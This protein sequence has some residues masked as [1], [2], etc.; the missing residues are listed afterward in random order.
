MVRPVIVCPLHVPAGHI[1]TGLPR[2][3]QHDRPVRS[4]GENL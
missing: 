1:I 2:S 3:W 4:P